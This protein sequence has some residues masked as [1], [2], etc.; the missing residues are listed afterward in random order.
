MK[1]PTTLKDTVDSWF[2]DRLLST[3]EGR[4]H[5]L[6]Q[7]ADAETSGE[8]RIFEQ[9][10][11]RV[12][13]PDLARMIR[14]HQADEI[15]HAEIFF[16]RVD[17][18]GLPRT[19]VP[20]GLRMLE[21]LDAAL[22]NPLGRPITT[23][24]GVMDA[25]LLLQVIE[26]RAITQFATFIDGF[27]RHDPKT[28][29]VFELV[30]KDEERH[31]RYCHAVSRRYAPDE[32]TRTATLSKLRRVEA[33]VFKA[34]QLANVDH[35]LRNKLI[36]GAARRLGWRIFAA[37]GGALPIVPMTPFAA[38]AEQQQGDAAVAVAA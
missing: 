16:E 5:V 25:Y 38:G 18:T 20:E 23:R 6:S 9:A 11:A 3:P 29:E 2:L 1:T 26:E 34:N 21:K 28:A 22:G 13:D 10:L 14:K 31:L 32:A 17:A 36:G 8:A 35:V 30:Q 4:H 37:V 19:A 15:R 27:R 24:E 7:V 12:D 33:E